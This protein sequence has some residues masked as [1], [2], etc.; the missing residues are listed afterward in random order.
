MVLDRIRSQL[1]RLEPNKIGKWGQLQEW[2]D[3]KDSP[4]EHNRHFSHLWAVYPGWGLTPEATPELFEAARVSQ[5][6]R[7]DEATGWSMGWKV[8]QWARFRDGDHAMKIM[9]NLFALQE[10]NKGGLYA[11]L[12]DAHPPFQIDGNFGVTAG[13]AEMLVQ[14][15]RRTKDGK[16]IIDVLPA[17]P[18]EWPTGSVKGLRVRGNHTVDIEWRNHKV[19]KVD[20]KGKAKNYV[21]N[22]LH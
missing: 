20:V 7:G 1:P 4:N 6:A 14:S 2:M 10:G 12:F 3:D 16:F 11:N 15:H 13:I 19:V 5:T 22:A 8:C 17:L 9:D 18:K 21:I